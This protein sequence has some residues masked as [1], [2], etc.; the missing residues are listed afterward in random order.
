MFDEIAR[1]QAKNYKQMGWLFRLLFTFVML[2]SLGLISFCGYNIKYNIIATEI[3]YY[4]F[5]ILL[6]LG[7]VLFG[8]CA[9]GL[10]ETIRD[11]L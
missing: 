3:E 4:A 10:I 2:F 1:A 6:I 7:I 11:P 9:Y 5:I 8:L